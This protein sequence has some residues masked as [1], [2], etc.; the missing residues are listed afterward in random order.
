MKD[1]YMV[2]KESG[3]YAIYTTEADARAAYPKCLIIP[4]AMLRAAPKMLAALEFIVNDAPEGEDAQ[5][6]AEGY[7]RAC[8]ALRLARGA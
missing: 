6:T 8:A 5:L 3:R 1:G 2:L 7:N 4:T